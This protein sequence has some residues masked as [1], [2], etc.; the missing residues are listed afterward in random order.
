MQILQERRQH[1]TFR[2]LFTI[3]YLTVETKEI[4]NNNNNKKH[5]ICVC[6]ANGHQSGSK[7]INKSRSNLLNLFSGQETL[8]NIIKG[9]FLVVFLSPVFCCY[10]VANIMHQHLA[11]EN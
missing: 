3:V 1:S 8:T 4:N 7:K 6:Y 2:K 10:I 11:H 9:H 5:G